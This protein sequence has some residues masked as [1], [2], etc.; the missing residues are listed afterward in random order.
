MKSIAVRFLG[1][2]LESIYSTSAEVQSF[3]RKI[4][5]SLGRPL[6]INDRMIKRQN[7]GTRYGPEGAN[8]VSPSQKHEDFQRDGRV[9][10]P[11]PPRSPRNTENK[12][13]AARRLPELP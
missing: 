7:D 12:S 9:E 3:C 11:R 4:N 8:N 1:K 5:L 13:T 2:R 10:P 6:I